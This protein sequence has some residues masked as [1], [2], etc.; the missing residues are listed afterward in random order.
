MNLSILLFACIALAQINK[1]VALS[2]H[3]KNM[4]E[5]QKKRPRTE[6]DT[7]S[8]DENDLSYLEFYSGVGGWTMAFEEALGRLEKQ[9]MPPMKPKRI[10]AMDHSDL[11][12]RVFEHNFGGDRKLMQKQIE[13]LT[14]KQVEK[15]KSKFWFMS[16][17]CRK[18]VPTIYLQC[19]AENWC[20]RVIAHLLTRYRRTPYKTTL[21]SR[22]GS[23][24]LEIN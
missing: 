16:P 20:H 13:R 14:K 5:R 4:S 12:N 21:Q 17:P 11:C 23:F 6:N 18:F 19:K 15:W 9:E 22:E 24:W 7:R 3:I 10:T 2:S 1:S 8:D